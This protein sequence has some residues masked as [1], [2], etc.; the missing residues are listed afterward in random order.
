MNKTN[1]LQSFERIWIFRP[2]CPNIRRWICMGGR[3][4]YINIAAP[5]GKIDQ[6]IFGK[7]ADMQNPRR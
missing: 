1:N 6:L 5:N 4:I 7:E 2:D 3:R